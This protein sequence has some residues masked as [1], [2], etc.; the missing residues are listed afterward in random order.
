ME[1][2]RIKSISEELELKREIVGIRWYMNRITMHVRQ[3]KPE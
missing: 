3:N 1:Q 2:K